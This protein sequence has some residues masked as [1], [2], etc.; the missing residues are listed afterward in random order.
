MAWKRLAVTRLAKEALALKEKYE[1]EGKKIVTKS[2]G[3]KHYSCA[4]SNK[5]G[6][7]WTNWQES[8]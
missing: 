3:R 5:I 2:I 8:E 4:S 1:A 7:Y 6:I